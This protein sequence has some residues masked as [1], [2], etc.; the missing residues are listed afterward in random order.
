MIDSRT[1][2]PANYEE[3]VEHYGDFVKNLIVKAGI[4]YQ[5]VEDVTQ[6]I[7]TT[8]YAKGALAWYDGDK[9]HPAGKTMKTA[10]FASFLSIF[11]RRYVLSHRD[12][13]YTLA[14]KVPFR[15][16]HVTDE[17]SGGTYGEAVADIQQELLFNVIEASEWVEGVMRHLDSLEVRGKRD[18]ARVFRLVVIQTMEDGEV[19]RHK[20]ASEMDVSYTA[21]CHMFQDLR[22][23]LKA[24]GFHADLISSS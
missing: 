24:A 19:N 12:K 23:A 18:L 9:L 16:E 22:V 6:E 10:R 13:Q 2:A 15:L 11:V 20:I 5:D 3:L 8:F 21:I 4:A 7:L 17:E 1:G 14:R